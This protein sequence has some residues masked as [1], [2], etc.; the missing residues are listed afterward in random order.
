MLYL[1]GRAAVIYD[2][3]AKKM[4]GETDIIIEPERKKKETKFIL[5]FW[6][7]MSP[8]Y[9]N[10]GSLTIDNNKITPRELIHIIFSSEIFGLIPL[11]LVDTFP[12]GQFESIRSSGV[13]DLIHSNSLRKV[14]QFFN[15]NYKHYNKCTVLIPENYINQFNESVNFPKDNII[16]SLIPFFESKFKENFSVFKDLEDLLVFFTNGN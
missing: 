4:Q 10:D 14:E 11:E 5:D 9:L 7:R 6:R 12:M 8:N 16:Y 2:N 15:K 13:N 1:H 3:L